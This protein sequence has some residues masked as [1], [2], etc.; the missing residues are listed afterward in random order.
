MRGMK[1]KELIEQLSRIDGDLLVVAQRD[2]DRASVGNV[3]IER[4][5]VAELSETSLDP[6]YDIIVASDA[7]PGIPAIFIHG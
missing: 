6:E 5:F 2:Y 7:R 1:I 3:K 4:L